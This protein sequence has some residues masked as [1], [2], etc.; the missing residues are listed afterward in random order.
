MKRVRNLLAVVVLLLSVVVAISWAFEVFKKSSVKVGNLTG[1]LTS[2]ELTSMEAELKAV[3]ES[4]ECSISVD[5]FASEKPAQDY[6]EK[7]A[8]KL[9]GKFVVC[10]YTENS[11]TISYIT[12]SGVANGLGMMEQAGVTRDNLVGTLSS[13]ATSVSTGSGEKNN[14][15]RI[16]KLDGQVMSII[17]RIALPILSFGLALLVLITRK[18]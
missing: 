13:M 9:S 16:L 12:S 14:I 7:M 2:D 3:V 5:V 4:T 6:L 15:E 11:G 1:V 8:G 18:K 10:V 17:F